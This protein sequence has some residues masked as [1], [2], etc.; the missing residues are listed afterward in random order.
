MEVTLDHTVTQSPGLLFCDAGGEA[1]ILSEATGQYYGLN[2]MGMRL[3]QALEA[4][5][6]LAAAYRSV[7]DEYDVT[8]VELERDLLTFVQ[9]L[10]ERR[11][12]TVTSGP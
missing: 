4:D 3:W 9:A 10:A 2:G 12:V 7:L 5:G 1:V 11:L 6:Q 8:P